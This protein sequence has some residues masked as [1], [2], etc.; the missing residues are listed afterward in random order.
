MIII[1]VISIL[2]EFQLSKGKLA[3]SFCLGQLG[4]GA[5]RMRFIRNINRYSGKNC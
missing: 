2:G 3:Q 1:D 5:L 4:P